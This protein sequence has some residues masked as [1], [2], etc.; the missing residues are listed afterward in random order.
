MTSPHPSATGATTRRTRTRVALVVYAVVAT[1]IVTAA[2]ASSIQRAGVS[3]GLRTKATLIAPAAAGGGWDTFMRESQNAMRENDVATNVQVLNVPG[4][5][6]TI[7]LTSLERRE[8]EAGTAM[9]G[10]TGLVAGVEQLDSAVTLSDVTPI[11]RVVEEYDVIVVPGDSPYETLDDLVRAW[12]KDP[13][14][15]PFTGGGSFDQLVMAEL[16]LSAGIDPADVSYIPASGG[17]EVAQSLVTETAAA[18]A[19]GFPDVDDQIES[20]RLRALGLVAEEP[21]DGVDIPTLPSLG[22][23]VTL[24]N[25]RAV[26][27]PPD[28][29]ADEAEEMREVYEEIVAT[30]EWESAV[31]RNQ[32]TDVWLD[33]EDFREFLAE[34]EARV[35]ELYEELDL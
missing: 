8:G 24:T 30:E 14:K 5:A 4:A 27:G 3:P 28:I 18:A 11:A 20:G 2:V 22:Y 25:W 15:V 1:V 29:S 17:G 13:G 21:L 33:G 7:G 26:F 6:G 31:S 23:D 10:G 12:R 34:E 35:A 32:W 9:V 16:A 19:S